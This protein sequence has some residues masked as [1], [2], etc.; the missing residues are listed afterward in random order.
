MRLA[1]HG[2]ILTCGRLV[3]VTGNGVSLNIHRRH[4]NE[5]QRAMVAANLVTIS[6]RQLAAT[7]QDVAAG[8]GASR[9]L[10]T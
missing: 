8:I 2:V 6:M 3:G 4:L 5:S 9:Q 1:N 7:S 10:A